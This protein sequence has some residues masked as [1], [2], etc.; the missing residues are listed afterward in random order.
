[1]FHRHVD[2]VDLVHLVDPLLRLDLE[3]HLLL[4]RLAFPVVH[5]DLDILVVPRDRLLQLVL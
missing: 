4:E 1:M 2:L 3:H 5:E